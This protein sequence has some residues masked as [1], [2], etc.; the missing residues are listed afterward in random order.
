MFLLM[1]FKKSSKF[2]HF[3]SIQLSTTLQAT[4]LMLIMKKINS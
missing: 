3:M 4:V 1:N 2:I